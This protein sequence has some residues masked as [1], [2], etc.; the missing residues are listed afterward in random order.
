MSAA[1]ERKIRDVRRRLAWGRL[2]RSLTGS[3]TPSLLMACLALVVVRWAGYEVST[4]VFAVAGLG[5]GSAVG[6]ASAWLARPSTMDAALEFDRAFELRERVS[7][8]QTM[9]PDQLEKPFGK[10]FAADVAQRVERLEVAEKIPVPLP[11]RGWLPLAPLAALVVTGAFL[12]PAEWTTSAA[13]RSA[14]EQE[15]ERI[16]SETKVLETKLA[17]RRKEADEKDLDPSLKELTNK[18]DAANRELAQDRKGGVEDAVLKLSDLAK[19]VEDER[20]KLDAVEQIKRGLQQ[21]PNGT[22]GPAS[23]LQEAL[24]K[25]DFQKAAAQL[26]QLKKDLADKK[27]DADQREKLAKQ[28]DAL[29]KKLAEAADQQKRAEQLRK[30]LPP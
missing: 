11:K 13:G 18:I 5:I 30:N 27:L 25:G 26:E 28:L 14:S 10:A 16:A 23:K 9:T 22:E 29:Q 2:A 17:E 1:I 12:S 8:L 3:L 24:K 15:K 21:L 19:Q 6:V 7:T 4:I 20:R